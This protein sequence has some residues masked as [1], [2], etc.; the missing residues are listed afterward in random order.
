MKHKI[1][2]IV[3]CAGLLAGYDSGRGPVSR[4]SSN[5]GG[6]RQ[7]TGPASPIETPTTQEARPTEL[8]HPSDESGIRRALSEPVTGYRNAARLDALQFL[9][10]TPLRSI[11]IMAST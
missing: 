4:G 6:V 1:I 9:A 3:A 10:A 8:P 11:P 2:A 5:R 7:A